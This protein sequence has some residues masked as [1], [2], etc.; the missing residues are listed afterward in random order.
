MASKLDLVF[1]DTALQYVSGRKMNTD[2][3][4]MP[5]SCIFTHGCTGCV[6]NKHKNL[7]ETLQLLEPPNEIEIRNTLTERV[8]DL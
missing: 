5:S 3:C 7:K 2:S 1:K 8:T 6:F 4:P